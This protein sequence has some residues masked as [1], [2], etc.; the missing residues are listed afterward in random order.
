[1]KAGEYVVSHF[2]ESRILRFLNS[3]LFR[4]ITDRN[5]FA[6]GDSGFEGMQANVRL[7]VSRLCVRI[8]YFDQMFHQNEK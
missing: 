8:D 3:G 5:P 7:N 1:M 6:V 2:A 4:W